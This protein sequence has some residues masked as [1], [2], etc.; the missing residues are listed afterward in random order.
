MPK[1]QRR[2]PITGRTEFISVSVDFQQIYDMIA[3]ISGNPLKQS[4]AVFTIGEDIGTLASFMSFCLLMVESGWLV[5]DEILVTDN[6]AVYTGH[7]ARDL[8]QWF[9]ELIVEERPLHVLVIYLPTKSPELNPIELVF[10]IF[11]HRIRS[12]QIRRNGGPVDQAVIRY[13][14]MVMEEM[15]YETILNCYKH[16]GY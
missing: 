16:C 9:W 15:S 14:L 13:G 8:E 11:S 4:H 2:C 6:A 1:K 10:H 7:E 12:Y 3:C 5:H